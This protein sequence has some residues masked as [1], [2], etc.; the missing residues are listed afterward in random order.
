MKFEID[1]NESAYYDDAF[2]IDVLGGELESANSVKYAP[3]ERIMLEV[4]DFE[5]L[6]EILELV[7][8]KYNTISTAL[9]SF[10]SPTIFLEI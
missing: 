3:F 9:V 6:K 10:D 7:D 2:L 1:F 5:H 4:R 8:K